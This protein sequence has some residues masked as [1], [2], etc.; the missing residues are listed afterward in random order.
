MAAQITNVASHIKT[1]QRLP[2]MT[3][4]REPWGAGLAKSWPVN[5]LAD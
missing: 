1:F 5:V 2:D 4:S 3:N